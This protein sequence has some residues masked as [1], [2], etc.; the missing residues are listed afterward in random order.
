MFS[1]V[2]QLIGELMSKQERGDYLHN[3]CVKLNETWYV[4]SASRVDFHDIIF[5]WLDLQWAGLYALGH[6]CVCVHAQ[7]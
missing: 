1:S 2:K 6:V 3:F 7:V 5:M 4:S